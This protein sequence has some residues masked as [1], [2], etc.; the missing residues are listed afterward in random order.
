M[1]QTLFFVINEQWTNSVLDLFMAALS[2]AEIWRPLF[3]AI[4]LA[5]SS[6]ADSKRARS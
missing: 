6:L 1:D 2:D 5:S 4:E 3:V